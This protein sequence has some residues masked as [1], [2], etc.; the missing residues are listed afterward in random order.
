MPAE[1]A[2]SRASTA[3]SSCVSC[4]GSTG[5]ATPPIRANPG[6]TRAPVTCSWML[7]EALPERV[8]LAAGRA[9]DRGEEGQRGDDAI[10]L[11]EQ[12]ADP[13]GALGRSDAESGLEGEGD[14]HLEENA[15]SQSCRLASSH[16]LAV[17]AGL[18]EL[19]G[20]AVHQADARVGGDH[21]VVGDRRPAAGS[22]GWRRGGARQRQ[23]ARRREGSAA[24][25][26]PSRR[27]VATRSWCQ[28]RA[29]AADRATMRTP[30]PPGRRSTL[31]QVSTSGPPRL[32]VG[33]RGRGTGGCRPWC[34]PCAGPVTTSSA[35]PPCPTSPGC[36]PR[37]SSRACRCCPCPT[38]SR[39]PTSCCSPCRTTCCPVSSR[40]SSTRGDPRRA[41]SWPTR[42]VGTA[43]RSSSRRRG[44]GALPLAIHPVMTF[45]GT[46]R[47]PGAAGR[48]PVRGHVRRCRAT[49]RRGA[50][51]GD[52]RR[53]G[54]GAGR[55]TGA[56]P[57]GRRVRCELPHDRGAAVTRAVAARPA[58]SSPQRLMAPLLSASL[59]NALRHGDTALTG[60]V[61]RGDAQ[62]VADAPA[63]DSRPCLR[64]WATRYR[65]LARLTADRAWRP[66]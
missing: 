30:S 59:D 55:G 13:R 65:A 42:R 25:P 58:W 17:V 60:P 2:S 5:A 22:P 26:M 10:R 63:A 54:L 48:L 29:G 18:E 34:R 51:R 27:S 9:G 6:W 11:R 19:L 52:G 39:T 40:V 53:S 7:G 8:D 35:S 43:R 31:H 46:T 15:D 37:R 1:G 12:G 28:M 33:D 50:G 3:A 61:A 4:D 20:A 57:R 49:G 47:R 44:V 32:R 38:S 66:A 56:V 16:R 24:T 14:T 36:A 21:E 41:S 45:T 23:H 62:T 64:S